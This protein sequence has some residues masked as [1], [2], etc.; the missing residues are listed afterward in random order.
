MPVGSRL[1]GLQSCMQV[2]ILCF[3]VLL[4]SLFGTISILPLGSRGPCILFLLN[5]ICSW[6][7]QKRGAEG[8]C[9]G[10]EPLLILT[11]K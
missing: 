9:T 4:L 8:T 10:K 3:L 11:C 2:K 7:G 5:K 1:A 6:Q